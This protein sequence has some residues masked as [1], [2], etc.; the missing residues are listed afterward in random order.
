MRPFGRPVIK[1]E[2]VV[3][4]AA[5][6]NLRLIPGS[7]GSRVLE[8]LTLRDENK[9]PPFHADTWLLKLCAFAVA[10]AAVGIPING[11]LDYCF[12]LIAAVIVFTG[13]MV[14][15]SR[16]WLVACCVVAALVCG[17]WLIAPSTI[18]E[19][20]NVFLGE[21]NNALKA[22]LPPDVFNFMARQ[23]DE[24]YPVAKRC[25]PDTLWCWRSEGLLHFLE[26]QSSYGYFPTY[27]TCVEFSSN[28]PHGFPVRVYAFS[29]DG[30]FQSPLYSRRVTSI[31]FA[32]P[33]WLRFGFLND[34]AYNWWNR[35]SDVQRAVLDPHWW[36]GIHRWRI[37]MPWFVMYRF[38]KAYVGSQLCWR[39]DVL[40]ETSGQRFD[41]LHHDRQACQALTSED[42]GRK[43]F[44]IAIRPDTLAM[45]LKPVWPIWLA[46]WLTVALTFAG[47]FLTLA[48]LVRPDPKRAI[49]PALLIVVTLALVS[50]I[51]VT[52]LGGLRAQEGGNDG[53]FY[54][55]AGR[56]I[57][58]NLLTGDFRS[59]LEGT[60]HVYY[61]GGPGLR[62]LR[63]L[64]KIIFGETNLGYLSLLL[65]FPLVVWRLFYRFLSTR[66]ALI[67]TALFI[68][69]PLGVFFGTTFFFYVKYA[70][71]GFSDTA[72]YM[73]FIAGLA[74][75]VG[76]RATG[77]GQRFGPAAGAGL[78]FML[79]LF[80]RP[81]VAPAVAVILGGAGLASLWQR[82][83]HRLAGL[84]VGFVPT[85]V[86]PL[87]NWYFGGVFVPFSANVESE[88]LHMP[89]H[90]YPAAFSELMHLNFAGPNLHMA[91]LQF[92]DFPVEFLGQWQIGGPVL[93]FL[94]AVVH[95]IAVGI[96]IY[97]LCWGRRFELWLRLIAGAALAQHSVALFY[98]G[99]IRYFFLAWFLTMLVVAV[100]CKQVAI[101]WAKARAPHFCKRMGNSG[102]MAKLQALLGH[103]E[104]G[105]GLQA[106]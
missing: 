6:D 101:P 52:T 28:C 94:S 91:Y 76:P 47:I 54:E 81:V 96:V 61:Y 57:L 40:W 106:G 17:K 26:A 42:V 31:D 46:N 13:T 22:G 74:A 102:L 44:G 63:A 78:L 32:D 49:M 45:H 105:L 11:F 93:Y 87:H 12:L 39:G 33:A 3:V 88:V 97:V 29:A 66:W 20:H 103:A 99:A 48:I 95:W 59:A 24:E 25:D 8:R 41:T 55:A 51:D 58:Q 1:I 60:E 21:H 50:I 34:G 62:Y 7:F 70:L 92:L 73:F 16:R 89:P 30:I 90:A 37:T 68:V 38:P 23:F 79:A 75:I 67:L 86:M 85:I 56:V 5:R 2:N 14:D 9:R 77:A 43:I 82:Q 4:N 27:R 83:W 18:E 19:G 36:H 53:L 64:E 71:Q 104:A 15:T 80:V 72:S 98:G 10:V 35:A 65:V 84:C 100:W 69:T